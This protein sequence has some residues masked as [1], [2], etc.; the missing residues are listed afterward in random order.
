MDPVKTFFANVYSHHPVLTSAGGHK[1][2]FSIAFYWSY[3]HSFYCKCCLCSL[4][5]CCCASCCFS[6][7]PS[8]ELSWLFR[9][10]RFTTTATAAAFWVQEGHALILTSCGLRWN[11][12]AIFGNLKFEDWMKCDKSC[13][14]RILS[15]GF[16]GNIE[17]KETA[18]A[19][20]IT[21][22]ALI[23]TVGQI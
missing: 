18:N 6:K 5:S 2:T 20:M 12:G 1:H 19:N 11:L 4:V 23:V 14:S 16:T 15:E 22:F 9:P 13:K 21:D 10:T 7:P 3:R 17:L 8:A